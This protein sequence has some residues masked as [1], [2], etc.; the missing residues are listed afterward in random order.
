M[1]LVSVII[2]TYKRKDKLR[3][4]LNSL[5][6]SDYPRDKME[7]IVVVDADGE[8]YSDLIKEFPMVTFVFN[9][10]EKLAAESRNIG[11]KL[12]RGKY[13]FFI[14]D[15]NIVDKYAIS[16][17]IEV[18]E[19]HEDAGL[20]GPLMLFYSEPSKIWCAGAVVDKPLFRGIHLYFGK[21]IT[22]IQEDL[23]P[24]DYIPNFYSIPAEIFREVGGFDSVS[25]PIAWEE[26][27]LAIRVKKLGYKVLVTPKAITWHDVPVMREFHIT[28]KRAYFRGRSRVLF[29]KKHA[30]WRLILLPIDIIGF[31]TNLL[32]SS[33]TKNKFEK[34]IQYVWGIVHGL[35]S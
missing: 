5:L 20:V 11:A 17:I 9:D 35:T 21:N 19:T 30:P 2:P 8:D 7:I 26:V 28:P 24:C 23:I 29:Y 33:L 34:F 10:T 16:K 4:L 32:K 31:T 15:D 27:D 3:R 12:A 1:P 18:F 13:L 6:E 14:D 22:N 25:F